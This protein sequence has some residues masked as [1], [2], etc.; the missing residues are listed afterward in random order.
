MAKQIYKATGSGY[1]PYHSKMEGGFTD[2]HGK[3]L[4]TLQDFLDKK[5]KYVSVAMDK[6]LPIKYGTKLRIP[7]LDK[8]YNREIEFR[9]V[10]TGDAFDHK[11]Y[12]RI[13]ICTRN[14]H[15]SVEATING[16]LTLEFD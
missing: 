8:K 5:A 7:E 16:E 12:T 13:D 14:H 1:Y 4:H 15:A 10:D 3:P 6:Y 11:G 2:R 9:V